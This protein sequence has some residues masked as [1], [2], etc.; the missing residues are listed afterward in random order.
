M[1]AHPPP[2][3]IPAGERDATYRACHSIRL[4]YGISFQRALTELRMGVHVVKVFIAL[5]RLRKD[6]KERG[7][8][9]LL[10][11]REEVERER[12]R[13]RDREVLLDK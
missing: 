5:G 12:E 4:S 13:E 2:P 7:R 8:E 6:E 3:P 9:V 1:L 10:R 11:C